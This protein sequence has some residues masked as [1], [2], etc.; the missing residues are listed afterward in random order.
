MMEYT[1]SVTEAY[2]WVSFIMVFDGD[3]KVVG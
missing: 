2:L 1:M 3:L